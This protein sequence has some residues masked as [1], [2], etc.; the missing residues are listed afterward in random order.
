MQGYLYAARLAIAEIASLLK[1]DDLSEKLHAQAAK[2]KRDF[3]RDFWMPEHEFPALA[4]D[5]EG[6]QVKVISSNAGHCIWAGI[7]DGEM[8][9]RVAD[10]LLTPD[11]DSGWG[12]RTLSTQTSYYNPMSY[13]NG[14][15]WPHDNAIIL[16]GFRKI[17]RIRD[18]HY[19]LSAMTAVAQHQRDFRLPELVCGFERTNWGSPIDYPVSCSPQ[20][21]A[22]GSIF[23]MLSACVNFIPDAHKKCLRIEEPCLPE[24]LE[25]VTFHNLKVGNAELD[26]AFS[27]I[28]GNTS[29][30]ILRKN[31]DLKVIIEN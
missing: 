22:A 8:A 27:A 25:K 17:G 29:C 12:L 24:W 19:L 21:W 13:H 5:G 30:Q 23:Q 15:V 6:R 11:M 16:E 20:A 9:Q 10:R 26:I 2:L 18:A 4:L 1:K 7:L 31:G 14:S 3:K 28:N